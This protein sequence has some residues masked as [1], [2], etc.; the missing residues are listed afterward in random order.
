LNAHVEFVAN[1]RSMRE[2]ASWVRGARVAHL[3]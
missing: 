3:A 2:R 1:G